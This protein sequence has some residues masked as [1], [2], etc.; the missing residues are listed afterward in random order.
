[1]QKKFRVEILFLSS[2]TLDFW[3]L[4]LSLYRESTDNGTAVPE[5]MLARDGEKL[6][7]FYDC[8]SLLRDFY[9][10]Y[11]SETFPLYI[12]EVLNCGAF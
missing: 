6:P 8:S 7:F 10:F 2:L 12:D 3:T 1:M 11:Q 4:D 9:S 5:N